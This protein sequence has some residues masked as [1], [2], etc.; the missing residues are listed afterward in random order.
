M[1]R[2]LLSVLLL[3]CLSAD[4]AWAQP[5]PLSNPK[6]LPI[7]THLDLGLLG[8][9]GGSMEYSLDGRKIES[10]GDFKNLIYPLRDAEASNL[11]RSAE[12]ADLVSWVIYGG[13]IA[14]GIDVALVFKPVPVFNDDALDRISTGLFVAQIGIGIWN[15]FATNAEAR[16]FN[17][18]QRYN[19]VLKN[20]ISASL[21]LST[22]IV[23]SQNG[24]SL[25]MKT[26][27]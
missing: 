13:S 8:L 16:K 5:A 21:E 2:F 6:K 26:V 3:F 12:Q 4:G 14:V 15:I 9:F 10:Y 19:K 7:E 24:M 17:A 11:I 27:F 22:E 25:G 1:H 20:K 23:A 18:V